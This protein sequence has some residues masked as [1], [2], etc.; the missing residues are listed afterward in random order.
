MTES[1]DIFNIH[2]NIMD[3][4]KHFVRSFVN[5]K[6]ERIKNF[7]EAG[8]NE[9]KFWPEP[10]IQFNPSFEPGESIQ[11][12]IDENI[13]HPELASIFKGF[14]LFKHQSEAL[15]KG[16]KGSDFVVT[17]GTGS[18]KSLTFIGTIFNY[19]LSNKTSDGVKAVI[20]YPMNALI[21]SQ[22]EEIDKY[23]EIYEK[24]TGKDF[25][26]SFGQYTGQESEDKREKIKNQMPDIILT[27][28]MMM[29][30][31]L[32]RSK[33]HEIRKS[34]FKNLKFLVFDELHTYRGR[35]GSDIAMLI[36]RIKAQAMNEVSCIGTSATMVSG[37]TINDQKLKVAEVAT[38]LFG[39]K[40]SQDQIIN[41]YLI[42][43]FLFNGN[44]PNQEELSSFLNSHINPDDDENK[45]MS[46]PLGI[47]LENRIALDESDGLLIRN[48]PL[49]FSEIVD[50]LSNDSGIDKDTCE[51]QM[52]VFLKWITN[53]N[54][55]LAN[56]RAAYLPYKI[57]QFISQTG[58]VYVSLN[59]NEDSSVISLDPTHHKG[60]GDNKI[61]IFPVVFSRVSG[62]EFICVKKDNKNNLLKPREF[63]EF[64][65]EDEEDVTAG[66]IFTGI[67]VWNPETDLEQLPDT[68]VRL[69]KRTGTYKP[70]KEYKDRL[71]QK[72]YY[73]TKGNFSANNDYE[74][75]G[76]F[77]SVK[78]LFDPTSGTQYDPNTNESTKLTR[79]GSEGRSTS[80]TV[81]SH[82]TLNQLSDNGF[83]VKDQKLLSFTDNRQDAALQ[84]GH[85][86]DTLKVIEFRSAIYRALT[87]NA[88]LDFSN[89]GQ[90]VFDAL[91]LSQEEY[92]SSVSTFPSARTD[93]E[94]ALK[95]YLMY[96]ALY[97]L[98]RGW[99]VV[100]PNL[101][102]CALLRINYRHLEENC[103]SKESW[104][105]VPLL[106]EMTVEE[107]TGTVFQI[108]D[109][110]RKSY[111]LYS[112]EY[113]TYKAINEKSKIIKEKLRLPWKFEDKERIADPYKLGYE[114]LKAGRR[115]YWNSVGA[116]STLGKYLKSIAKNNGISLQ[117]GDT[118]KDFIKT[119][120]DLLCGA[121]WLIKTTAKNSDN[122]ETNLYQLKIDQ[123]V[124]EKGD[125]TTIKQDHVKNRSY[126]VVNQEPNTYYKDLYMSDLRNRKRLIGKEHTGQLG[127]DDRIDR[128][129]KFRS[130][131]YSVLFCS[132]T[133]E[134]GI[135]IANLNVIHLRN[136]PP[137]PANYAQRSG[138]AGRSG[139]P[140]LVFTSCSA[141]SPH[142]M[143]YFNNA[144][145]MVAGAVAPPEI[146]LSNQELLESHLNALYLSYANLGELNQ[147]LIDLM[148]EDQEEG[149]SLKPVV[150]EYLNLGQQ[151]R[152]E[153][154]SIFK[155]IIE[156]INI[157][158]NSSMS[159][160]N[161][162]WIDININSV[163]K[164]F[165]RS[166]E[167][168]KKLF[169]SIQKQLTDA[170]DI[171][172]SGRYTSDSTE[173]R[174]AKRKHSQATRQIDL[175]TNKTSGSN[176]SEFYPYRYL[177]SEGFLPGY[178]F[179]RLPIRVFI[180]RGNSGEY[181]SRPR[182][183][184]LREFGP[185]N[186]IYHSGSKYMIN[187]LLAPDI[188]LK[189][190]KAKVSTTSGYIMMWDE[191]DNE[192]CPFSGVSL[193]EANSKEIY[194]DLLE[195]ADASTVEM[196]QITCQEEERLSR[197]F[198]IKTYFSM[199]GGRIDSIRT[200][201]I[202]NEG[203][204]FLRIRFMPSAR[205][206]QINRKWSMSKERGFLMGLRSGKW[207]SISREGSQ[208]ST[209][210]NKYIQLFTYDTA[211]ALYIEPITSLALS[212]SGV[213]TLQYA[214]KRAVE[215]IFQI[216][217]R[218][219]GAELMGDDEV[220]NIFLYEASEGSLGIL[221]QFIENKDVFKNVIS[222]AIKVCRYDDESYKD[223]ASYNDLLSYYNQ[224]FHD[225]I[226]RFEIKDALEKLNI[227]DVEIITNTSFNDYEE[228][229][230]QLQKGID[231]NSDTELPFLDYLYN[232]G[233]RLPDSAQKTVDGIYCQPDFFYEPDV[234]VF[235]D[236][237]HH[238]KPEIIKRDKE[239][240]DAILNRGDQVF[241][242]HYKAK[243]AEVIG[244]RPDI[245]K[246]VK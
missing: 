239:Q 93:N 108:L 164:K 86:N 59:T 75:E 70:R 63:K 137:N 240:R 174:E 34:I 155:K 12:L 236:G 156:G 67:D 9:G 103:G 22:T 41:E 192:V 177:A 49:Q 58:T 246:K 113:L 80:T 230:R 19:L 44:I 170:N 84:S 7:V 138:R 182:F 231:P 99:R 209:E 52:K 232:N 111:A 100:L 157:N 11:A 162:E 228:Q 61:P 176:L 92:S 229:Y 245:F 105:N 78:L 186:I 141:Y 120:L 123:I 102:Q 128:E 109:F 183:I 226:N 45:L 94:N 37:G 227:C 18:G 95:D 205:L 168:W 218:E 214:L 17:S 68:W 51:K 60:S 131:E 133:M 200:A 208:E 172:K 175:L 166:L 244:K 64:I 147:S 72:I 20:V 83:E 24:G 81:L 110:F 101:E 173:K 211:D 146:D 117:G 32:T 165:E 140:A 178:N 193:D 77:M 207:K 223:E 235:C 42:R 222:E 237:I 27:N 98:R 194:I 169:K 79:L 215:N 106:H 13:L 85:F 144:T 121:G 31:I 134:L 30:L 48:R 234:W 243:L 1:I 241:V 150:I 204:D 151:K 107:R 127:Y 188:E 212:K 119:L 69:D 219:L 125:G 36:R 87:K 96:R 118:Y 54:K 62:Q 4:Y 88:T 149:L 142:D 3:S 122:K 190:E 217:S 6:N 189:L 216:E 116:T 225:V 55:N 114:K 184:A 76:W 221:S 198:Q 220:P 224:R 154:K 163:P 15:I 158:V 40:L 199:P 195:M 187:Q 91:G 191:Y 197:G 74:Y 124:W 196:E 57:H 201:K 233:L 202:K 39:S 16:S 23:K 65:D 161:D 73:N 97:D 115:V 112:E 2:R 26:F 143:H 56:S 43:K 148:D 82:S 135:D 145:D 203:E 238:D 160:L 10:L 90:A 152:N 180:P 213:I 5:I 181:L 89:M 25:P 35:Q 126:K 139:Q 33:E 71:P 50:K 167:R 242:Y 66:Y 210:E 153:I 46:S 47:W 132:P 171:I 206:V 38:K 129:D 179:T 185:R 130:G 53:V 14:D 104:E 29:E 8:I 159:W 21:N 136:V 28:Y